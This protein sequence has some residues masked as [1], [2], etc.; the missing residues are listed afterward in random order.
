MAANLPVDLAV[1]LENLSRRYG[2]IYVLRRLNVRI[3]VGKLVVLQGSN[4]SGK[5]TLLKVLAS[6]L[7]PS[8]GQARVMGL[9]VA[10]QAA[11]VRMQVGYMSVSGGHY[12]SL[13]ALENLRFAAALRYRDYPE[14]SLWALLE[15]VG[16]QDAAHK[17]SRSF[18]SGMHKRL[19]LAK[20]LLADA[21][22][23]LLDEPYASLDEAGQDVIDE[24][25][26]SAKAQ[27]KTVLVASHALER[28]RRIADAVL[29]LEQGQLSLADAPPLVS[30]AAGVS[31]TTSSATG[32]S[33]LA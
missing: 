8:R 13:S 7:R 10:S 3:S 2:S 1:E 32:V 9:D 26:R 4:G 11:Q 25:L 18:S 33:S 31:S 23:W 20:L 27:G 14:A 16:L 28:S 29:R 24:A 12:G 5:T 15:Q 6:R 30:G 19:G 21:P 17:L 22:L